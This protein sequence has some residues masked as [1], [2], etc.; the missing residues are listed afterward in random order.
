[1]YTDTKLS[2]SN[3]KEKIYILRFV[4]TIKTMMQ[5]RVCCGTMSAGKPGQACPLMING[6]CRREAEDNLKD[7]FRQKIRRKKKMRMKRKWFTWLLTMT[8]AAGALCGCKNTAEPQAQNV[9]EEVTVRVASLKGP[10]SMGLVRLWQ[11]DEEGSAK[12]SYEFNMMTGADEIMP[13]M[14]KGDVDIALLPANAAAI[15]YQKSEK[16]ISVIDINTLG[17]LYLVSG[18]QSI[19]GIED[20]RGRTV[21]LTG[22]GTTPD[23][24]LQYLLSQ[25]GIQPDEVALEYK[26]EATEVAALLKEQPEAIGLLPQP[27][28]TAACAQNEALQ[29][30]LDIN[31]EWEK[32]NDGNGLVTGVTV[33]RN[34]FLK[35]HPEAVALFM[36]EHKESAAFANSHVEE[37]AELVAAR[38][39]VE[40]AAVAAKAMPACNIT[41][42]DGAEMKTALSGY[43]QVLFEQNPE[44]IGGAVPED[45]YYLM[46]Q[47]KTEDA[48]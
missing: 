13:Q 18:D 42:I 5:A 20:L 48:E 14:I 3:D 19:A 30:V 11:D 10:T 22:K 9:T 38:G 26:S 33:V 31:E 25:H 47:K 46:L 2:V 4:F 36:E 37:A 6:V 44:F 21:Y 7:T 39:I 28:V 23:Y 34:A 16:S 15:L 29:V 24:A 17:V 35:E 45:E 12:G 40:K 8:L 1:M 27:F 43:L 32:L 41:Y